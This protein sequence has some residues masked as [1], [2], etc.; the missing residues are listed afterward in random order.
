MATSKNKNTFKIVYATET[1]GEE[2][3]TLSFT[4]E[5]FDAIALKAA[6]LGATIEDYFR[7]VLD[8]YSK[9]NL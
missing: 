8:I 1:T 2:I 6:E 7:E 3:A 5:E 4:S 9:L